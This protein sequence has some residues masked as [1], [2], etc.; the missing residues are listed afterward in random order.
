[1]DNKF[2]HL[3][4]ED[5]K[6]ILLLS[7]D[8][9]LPSGVGSVAREIVVNTAHHFNW[10]NVGASIDHPDTGKIFDMSSDVNKYSDIV[11]SNVKV[12]CNNGYGTPDLIR[13]LIREE[14]P[15][16]IMI[17]TD[18]RYW[19]WLFDME[20]E[21]RSQIP[22]FYLNI[23]DNFPAPMYNRPYYESVDVLMAISKQTKLINELV[24]ED[25]ASEKI[26]EYVPHGINEKYFYPIL[27][28]TQ[29]WKNLDIF[30]QT[31]VKNVKDLEFTIFFNSRNI[32]RK[33]IPDLLIA[34]K[35]FCDRVGYEKARKCAL[36]LHTEVV[37]SA[38]T[39][40]LAV[41]EALIPENLFDN[42]IF[43]T[44]KLTLGQMN[45]LYNAADV[46]VLL[47]NNEGWGLSL[48]ES[49]M[50]GKMIIANV[51][52][53]MQDQMRFED[54]NGNWFTPSPT[55]PS[56]HNGTYRSCGEWAI[57]VFPSTRTL[58]GSPLT[59]YIFEDHTKTEDVVQA[60]LQVYNMTPEE[61]SRRGMKGREW[62][63]SEESGMSAQNMSKKV[64]EVLDKGFTTF[65]K[66]VPYEV[67]KTDKKQNLLVKHKI[68]GY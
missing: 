51:T 53:G 35:E 6:K 68:V 17:F 3:K 20:R 47:S 24:L 16:A 55:V 22:I 32:R 37:S 25:K 63:L 48:T 66:R 26:I 64:I 61:R 8:I 23:W 31:L 40:L 2:R 15:D 52:G 5:R 59:P 7:D 41:K 33:S 45:M 42:V 19:L 18:P 58:I 9:R 12:L 29:D 62:V 44:G 49:M 56:N 14:K 27:K 1:M 34:Y 36:V 38:G 21:I 39:D 4:R 46:T 11:D 54:E 10:F 28:N 67:L 13:A 60:L 50:T 57:P 43:S 30:K 65:K